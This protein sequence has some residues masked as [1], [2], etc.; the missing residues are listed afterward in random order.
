MEKRLFIVPTLIFLAFLV[1]IYLIIPEY[2]SFLVSTQ[3]VK[4][5][6]EDIKEKKDFY[7]SLLV[8]QNSLHDYKP[9]LD[10]ID[11]ALPTEIFMPDLL[12]YFQKVTSDNGLLLGSVEISP[13]GDLMAESKIKLASISLMASGPVASLLSFLTALEKSSRVFEVK[14]LSFTLDAG[15]TNLVDFSF[16]IKTYSY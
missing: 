13:E 4:N 3:Q 10:R 9:V 8:V 16:L 5:L 2:K 15:S 12:A 1:I 14:Q 6:E 11:S 7:E